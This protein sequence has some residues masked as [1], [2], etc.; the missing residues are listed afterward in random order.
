MDAS[1]SG[2]PLYL[3]DLATLDFL[4]G[5]L[6]NATDFTDVYYDNHGNDLLWVRFESLD[7]VRMVDLV[8]SSV[9]NDEGFMWPTIVEEMIPLPSGVRGMALSSGRSEGDRISWVQL[10][11]LWKFISRADG[12]NVIGYR[13]CWYWHADLVRTAEIVRLREMGGCDRT[14]MILLGGLDS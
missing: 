4:L 8:T 1:F 6:D 7:L 12:G 14:T 2:P 5:S 11:T 13:F 9:G 10:P 3:S